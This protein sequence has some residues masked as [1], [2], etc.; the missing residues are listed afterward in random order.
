MRWFK[1]LIYFD[2]P[3]WIQKDF[4]FI[5]QH[6]PLLTKVKDDKRINRTL[7]TLVEH[8]NGHKVLQLMCKLGVNKYIDLDCK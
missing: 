8:H 4:N 6:L 1:A 5:K 2:N 7:G 3:K